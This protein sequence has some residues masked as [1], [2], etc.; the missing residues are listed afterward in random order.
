MLFNWHQATVSTDQASGEQL[1]H[2]A[3]RTCQEKWNMLPTY[4]LMSQITSETVKKNWNIVWSRKDPHPPIFTT[5]TIFLAP[6]SPGFHQLLSLLLFLLL[7]HIFA[8]I[9]INIIIR[10]PVTVIVLIHSHLSK[11]TEYPNPIPRNGQILC[12]GHFPTIW[13]WPGTANQSIVRLIKTFL[14]SR[15]T[16]QGE[17]T[18]WPCDR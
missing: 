6:Q 12:T 18:C 3:H 1:R 16:G 11:C 15:Y 7:F 13:Q 10:E 2:R 5:H 8:Q 4:S 14:R 17:L 9:V